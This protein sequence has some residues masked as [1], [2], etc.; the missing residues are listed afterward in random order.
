MPHQTKI[1]IRFS[2]VDKIGHV[3]NAVFLQYMETARVQYFNDVF[4]KRHNW[5]K[6]GFVV[7]RNEINYL[8][9]LYLNDEIYCTTRCIKIGNKSLTLENVIY[10]KKSR[11]KEKVAEGIGV[12]VAMDYQ[13]NKSMKLPH[14]WVK[15]I[16]V[17]ENNSL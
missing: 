9:P 5:D 12:L 4:G 1:Q 11:K 10:R 7:V 15:K 2:D 3:N 6:V 14:K 8:L 17:F 16:K 13:I